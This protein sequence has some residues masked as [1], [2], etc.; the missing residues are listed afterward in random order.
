MHFF[1][2]STSHML[3]ISDLVDSL[4]KLVLNTFLRVLTSRFSFLRR[5]SKEEQLILPLRSLL[6]PCVY[7]LLLVTS[8]VLRILTT[9]SQQ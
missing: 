4:V 8:H 7:I 6:F 3:H 1:G 5:C 2:F 9:F